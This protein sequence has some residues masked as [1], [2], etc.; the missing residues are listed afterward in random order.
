MNCEQVREVLPVYLEGDPSLTAAE[1]EVIAD[2][3][4]NC[5]ECAAEAEPLR[6]QVALLRGAGEWARKAGERALVAARTPRR[7][8]ARP[9][10]HGRRRAVRSRSRAG[11]IAA[12]AALLL[13][14]LAGWS[15]LEGGDSRSDTPTGRL[16]EGELVRGGRSVGLL[17][18]GHDY[19]VPDRA[20]ATLKLSG[21]AT[22]TVSGG[23]RFLLGEG[24]E[25]RPRIRL[26]RGR[27]TC[28][29]EQP[30]EVS[31]SHIRAT[32]CGSFALAAR[33]S[34]PPEAA[35]PQHSAAALDLT[36]WL[37]PSAVAAE[38]P[39]TDSF[40]VPEAFI[41]LSG[42][43]DVQVNGSR[44]RLRSRSAVVGGDGSQPVTGDPG[45][46]V[47]DM[48]SERTSLLRG[49]LSPRY[50]AMVAEYGARAVR[51]REQRNLPGLSP[52][53]FADLAW[54]IAIADEMRA[55]HARRLAALAA[56]EGRRLSR[57][58]LLAARIDVLCDL[59]EESDRQEGTPDSPAAETDT[60]A[61]DAGAP[62]ARTANPNEGGTTR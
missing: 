36:G 5:R 28:A 12:A 15:M 44:F 29:S 61:A 40:A 41:L 59:K 45:R 56:K 54:R 27:M 35:A 50:R 11:W 3:L 51:Y 4:A 17:K 24:F 6:E 10:R 21:G 34:R 39:G 52:E 62:A 22:L 49:L 43:A 58:D 19:T 42:W 7:I 25:T 55:A 60:S 8:A 30:F 47:A 23:S 53:Q 33:E 9:E 18:A 32:V 14:C 57:A 1:K 16:L 2:H 37:F 46:L 20:S 13:A 38:S 48:A 26:L 31:G